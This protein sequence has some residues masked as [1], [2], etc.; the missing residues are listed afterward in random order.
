M[1]HIGIADSSL[2][3]RTLLEDTKSRVGSDCRLL[4][5]E[6][7]KVGEGW[8]RAIPIQQFEPTGT[9]SP[10]ILY[11]SWQ[12]IANILHALR[13]IQEGQLLAPTPF[14]VVE[15]QLQYIY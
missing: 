9:G 1:Q 8:K 3:G 7:Y 5:K 6:L 14:L 15:S 4:L 11:C 13:K 2:I 10:L 12:L